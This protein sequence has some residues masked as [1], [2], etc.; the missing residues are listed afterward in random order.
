MQL[1]IA[2]T[3]SYQLSS[4]IARKLKKMKCIKYEMHNLTVDKTV[5]RRLMAELGE[6]S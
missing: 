5:E 3:K 6:I 2:K 1:L 4:K